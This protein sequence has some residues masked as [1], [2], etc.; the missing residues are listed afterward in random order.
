MI[1]VDEARAIALSFPEAVEG[2]HMDHPDFRVRNKIFATLWPDKGPAVVFVDSDRH[3]TMIVAQPKTFSLNGWS[4]N[5]GALNVHLD[6]I[7]V[8]QF[9]ALV[10]TSWTRKAPKTLVAEL[11]GGPAKGA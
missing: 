11:E 3:D 10:E 7:E 6:H 2:E 1:S 8:G 4:K 9:R 5:Y